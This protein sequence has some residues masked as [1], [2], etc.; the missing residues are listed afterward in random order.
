MKTN[1]KR[2][3]DVGIRLKPIEPNLL[4]NYTKFRRITRKKKKK[5][6]KRK[7]KKKT[8]KSIEI[9][10]KIDPF[11]QII[12]DSKKKKDK[13]EISVKEVDKE[14]KEADKEP[15]K[16]P[17]KGPDKEPDKEADKEADKEP[18][19]EVKEADKE[20]D[21][22]V[23]IKKVKVE[24]KPQDLSEKD[25]NVK[26]LMITASTEPEPKKKGSQIKLE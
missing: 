17:D 24:K 16:G 8:V 4:E 12:E 20:P 9:Y 23:E 21:K 15:D 6:K 5:K 11:S 18:D 26:N 1:R 19:K 2:L 3:G 13:Q 10:R 25:P 22:E 7:Q 14:V